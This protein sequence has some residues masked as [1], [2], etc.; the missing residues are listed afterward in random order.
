[1]S[2]LPEWVSTDEQNEKF[3]EACAFGAPDTVHKNL[4]K[5]M[6]QSAANQ[7]FHFSLLYYSYSHLFPLSLLSSFTVLYLYIFCI[8]FEVLSSQCYILL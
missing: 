1:M 2:K 3:G 7:G 6:M 4:K 8:I 5:S